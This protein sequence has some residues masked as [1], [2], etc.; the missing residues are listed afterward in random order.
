VSQQLKNFASTLL[1]GAIDGSTTSVVVDDG[2]VFPSSGDFYIKVENEMMLVTA[3]STNTL[4]VTRAQEGTTAASHAD[5]SLVKLT[6]SAATW[7]GW[8]GDLATFGGYAS[9]PSSPKT[10]QRY[11]ATDIDLGWRY[12]GSNWDLIH[13]V[14]I[15]YANRIDISGWTA[16]NHGTSTWTDING[17][18]CA[19]LPTSAGDNI[20]GYYKNIPTAPFTSYVL[21]RVKGHIQ[22]FNM[23][24]L[25]LGDTTKVNTFGTISVSGVEAADRAL[26]NSVTSFNSNQYR[27]GIRETQYIWFRINDDNT[28]WKYSYSHDGMNYHQVYSVARNTFLTATKVGIFCNRVETTW[29]STSEYQFL[30]YWET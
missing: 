18:L 19:Q 15:P 16:F 25:F 3:R 12:D 4:T 1:N 29:P 7:D 8:F 30:G 2:S 9:R 5:D 24:G 28:N 23:Q 27:K 11:Y 20:R 14:Y 6:L 21:C 17:V 26:Y 13:P 10:G 22:Q